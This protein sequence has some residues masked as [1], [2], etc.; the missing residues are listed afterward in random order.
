MNKDSENLCIPI[1]VDSEGKNII[2]CYKS[3][4]LN[5]GKIWP[6]FYSKPFLINIISFV[7]EDMVLKIKSYKENKI[8]IKN[9]EEQKKKKKLIKIKNNDED[10]EKENEEK[11]KKKLKIFQI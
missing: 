9:D 1:N 2:C 8:D 10:E 11:K 5:L 6:T 7:K 4:E 3:L